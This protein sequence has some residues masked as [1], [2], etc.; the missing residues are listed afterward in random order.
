[1]IAKRCDLFD[2]RA[3]DSKPSH[4]HQPASSSM[5]A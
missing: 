2:R 1:L 4:G 5:R 3:G